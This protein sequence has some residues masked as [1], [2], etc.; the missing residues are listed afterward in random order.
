M[1]IKLHTPV[2][3]NE[4][5]KSLK[6][7]KN[8]IYLDGTFGSGGHS[9]KILEQIGKNGRL[10]AID[11][12]PYAVKIANK[13]FDHRFCI[14]HGNFS[15]I[16]I[17]LK[18]YHLYKKL[19]G[20]ILDLGMSSMQLMSNTRGFSFNINSPLDMRMNPKQGISA[21]K[22]INTSNAK[23]IY[24]VLKSFG[25]E[26]FAKKI[27]NK[28]IITR[29]TQPISTT[30]ELSNLIKSIV[31]KKKNKHP[32]TKSF[33]AIRIFINQE[34]QELQTFLKKTLNFLNNHGRISVISFHSLEDRI[35]KQFIN[36]YSKKPNIPF[37]LPINENQ[38]HNMSQIKLKKINRIF[39]SIE[40]IKNNFKSRSAILRTA[41]FQEK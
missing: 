24:Y 4:T 40:E 20:I 39:P 31:P 15:N 16:D 22:W 9:K 19:D 14:I 37:N 2:L 11:K 28:I 38:I 12:D 33:Q 18:K 10:Y 8:G 13:I 27:T 5:I 3:L 26:K 34:L 17:L 30:Y 25:E 35:V 23:N 29:K 32:A 36:K 41:E 6:I 1:N 21:T 7:K